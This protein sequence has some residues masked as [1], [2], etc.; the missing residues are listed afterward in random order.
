MKANFQL[1]FL[2]FAFL[3]ITS[4]CDLLNN[5]EKNEIFF[6]RKGDNNYGDSIILKF[7]ENPNELFA[8]ESE[9]MINSSFDKFY[10]YYLKEIGK[11][12]ILLDKKPRLYITKF[13]YF[14]TDRIK[15]EIFNSKNKYP[16][17][18][19][20]TLKNNLPIY[21]FITSYD[22]KYS[23][24]NRFEDEGLTKS[25]IG[26]GYGMADYGGGKG[27]I[28]SINFMYV[29]NDNPTD[30]IFK[31]SSYNSKNEYFGF[32]EIGKVSSQNS[33]VFEIENSG[34]LN[35]PSFNFL[36]YEYSF[37]LNNKIS[38]TVDKNH[39]DNS[40]NFL[41]IELFSKNNKFN[42]IDELIKN[43]QYTIY[44]E[45]IEEKK[46]LSTANNNYKTNDFDFYTKANLKAIN[47]LN[48][49]NDSLK[50]LRESILYN[51]PTPNTLVNDYYGILSQ[52]QTDSLEN[53]LIKIDN[54][55]GLQIAVVTVY[56]FMY[57]DISNFGIKLYNKWGIGNKKTNY[58]I[59]FTYDF[60]NKRIRIT[61]GYGIE[62]IYTDKETEEIIKKVIEPM[63]R[64]QFYFKG[65]YD[66]VSQITSEVISKK[67]YTESK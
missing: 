43:C 38:K 23:G 16:L 31:L 65:I 62:K 35:P 13:N 55:F 33:G 64:D 44:G 10:S 14:L 30:K 5:K 56:P 52:N 60:I 45:H 46:I 12:G 37:H 7:K 6:S 26:K 3:L 27:K 61:N 59:L 18:F 67:G 19:I 36:K 48:L 53:N 9:Y 34:E 22:V 63:F 41:I 20:N 17:S 11:I 28:Y 40:E 2:L 25:Q 29:D 50:T 47:N 39:F 66:A 15:S 51:I 57:D 21:L 58:G 49:S 4:S 54:Q 1:N 8:L 42:N 32:I 24:G